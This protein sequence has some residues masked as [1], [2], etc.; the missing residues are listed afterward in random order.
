LSLRPRSDPGFD[1]GEPHH[2]HFIKIANYVGKKVGGGGGGSGWVWLWTPLLQVDYACRIVL[3]CL[4]FPDTHMHEH[5]NI[6][7][8]AWQAVHQSTYSTCSSRIPPWGVATGRSLA[9]GVKGG[10]P[11]GTNEDGG[12][13]CICCGSIQLLGLVT[14]APLHVQAKLSLYVFSHRSSLATP[15]LC[16]Q[17][18]IWP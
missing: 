11:E 13:C 1:N 18:P 8:R 7:P 14:M 3:A 10:G 4:Q 17:P 9:P 6:R 15:F 2:A 16:I 5:P 12:V